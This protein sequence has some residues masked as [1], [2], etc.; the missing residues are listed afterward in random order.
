MKAREPS[1]DWPVCETSELDAISH[2]STEPVSRDAIKRGAAEPASPG[3][4]GRRSMLC[5]CLTS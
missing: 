2:K 5:S 1:E 4:G 3:L